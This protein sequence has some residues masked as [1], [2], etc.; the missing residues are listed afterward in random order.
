MCEL[1]SSNCVLLACIARLPATAGVA[2]GLAARYWWAGHEPATRRRYLAAAWANRLS[3]GLALI[4]ALTLFGAFLWRHTERE[5]LTGSRRL[6]LFSD[7]MLEKQAEHEVQEALGSMCACGRL[8]TGHPVY[9]RAAD[10]TSRLLAANAGVAA[11]RDRRWTLVVVDSPKINATVKP[12]GFVLVYAGLASVANDDQLTIIV[13]HEFAH[14]LLRHTN[15]IGSVKLA[16][17]ALCLFPVIAAVWATMPLG[18][19]LLAHLWWS[20]VLQVCIV[21]P[22]VRSY[23]TEADRVGM[24]L[25]AYACVD[26]TQGYR[27]WDAMS[28][29]DGPY[30]P[31]RLF[32]WLTMHPTNETRSRHLFSLIPATTELRRQAGC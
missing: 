3:V 16:V 32:W 15:Q 13:G 25:A 23:E 7:R 19:N 8:D 22:C 31:S 14:C 9:A 5:P 11:V 4:A 20:V 18:W 1:L 12:N 21:L 28:K 27:F 17:D 29:M 6:F 10:A 26:V 30:S 24:E 2:A